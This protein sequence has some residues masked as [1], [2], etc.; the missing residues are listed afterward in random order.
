MGRLLTA[1]VDSWYLPDTSGVSYG[2]EHVKTSIV[3]NLIDREGRR[4]GYFHGSGYYELEGADFAGLFGHGANRPEMLAPYV[5]LVKLDA[6][7]RLDGSE[8]TE[9]ALDLVR[10]HL[11][12]RPVTNPVLRFRKR[13]EQDIEWLRAEGLAT[14]HQYAFATLRQFGSAAEL[15]GSLCAWL[16][17]R[18][19]Q[20]GELGKEF[21]ELAA[22]AK[23]AQ[24][25]LARMVSGRDID[26]SP[27]LDTM[28]RGWDASM[29]LLVER[30]A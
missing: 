16:A 9:A 5:E 28:E 30:Y 8:L 13:L 14:F 1:E 12:R 11:A 25:Q 20:I 19:E 24:F 4:L 10:H 2:I 23:T 29:E 27:I 15:T 3:P 22:H 26:I 18:G 17:E 7:K 6:I 21:S